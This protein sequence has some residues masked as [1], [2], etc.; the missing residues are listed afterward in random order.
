MTKAAAS[1]YDLTIKEISN[2]STKHAIRDET[3]YGIYKKDFCFHVGNLT[4]LIDLHKKVKDLLAFDFVD[5][6]KGIIAISHNSRYFYIKNRKT[7]DLIGIPNESVRQL[8][9]DI[10]KVLYN[11]ML[12]TGKIQPKN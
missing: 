1:T 3:I 2:G 6:R 5:N 9:K 7:N 11:N 10:G 4:N 12:A 8:S